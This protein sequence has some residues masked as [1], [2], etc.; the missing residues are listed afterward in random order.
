MFLA[1]DRRTDREKN[2][3]PPPPIFDLG[4]IKMFRK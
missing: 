4:G 1:D 2:N 3:M